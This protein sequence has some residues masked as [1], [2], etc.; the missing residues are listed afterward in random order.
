MRSPRTATKSSPR[1]PQLEKACAAT[2][3]Q[4]NQKLINSLKKNEYLNVNVQIIWT[5]KL[6]KN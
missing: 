6:Q 3:T 1:S 5:G 2:K 4:H